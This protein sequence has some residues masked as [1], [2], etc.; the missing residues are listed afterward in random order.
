[1]ATV[2]NRWRLSVGEAGLRHMS[3]IVPQLWSI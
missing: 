3:R 1:M 2:A